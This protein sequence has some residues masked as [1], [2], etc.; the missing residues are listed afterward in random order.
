MENQSLNS[1][2]VQRLLHSINVKYRNFIYEQFKSYGYTFP[3][4]MLMRELYQNPGI[5]LKELSQ[6]LGL[7]KSTVSGIVDRLVAQG[8]VNRERPDNNRR[9]IKLSIAP[10][11]IKLRDS[12]TINS[13]SKFINL[14]AQEEPE[15]IEK[16]IS[17]L[18]KINILLEKAGKGE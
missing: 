9:I 4:I 5:T 10:E 13:N 6:R 16:I 18:Q 11:M 3:Q 7:A 17:G 12:I 2:T 8:A 15:E 1:D 14:L